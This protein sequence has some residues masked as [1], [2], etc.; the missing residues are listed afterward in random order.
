M[1]SYATRG[2]YSLNRDPIK[3]E[4]RAKIRDAVKALEGK[5]PMGLDD[6]LK[7]VQDKN[8]ELEQQK[9]AQAGPQAVREVR[10]AGRGRGSTR[11]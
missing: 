2:V 11:N 7:A 1:K 5:G 8:R 10:G 6:M 9:A 3:E 4:E